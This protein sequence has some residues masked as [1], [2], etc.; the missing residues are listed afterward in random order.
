MTIEDK[1]RLKAHGK[2]RVS[3]TRRKR[4]RGGF[5]IAWGEP[6]LTKKFPSRKVALQFLLAIVRCQPVQQF[7]LKPAK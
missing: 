6:P 2:I 5:E 4:C 7:T 3:I 1:I